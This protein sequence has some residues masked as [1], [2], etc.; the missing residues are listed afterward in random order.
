[1]AVGTRVVPALLALPNN[2]D[3]RMASVAVP[4]DDVATRVLDAA[5]FVSV[6]LFAFL[7]MAISGEALGGGGGWRL[8]RDG[9][10]VEVTRR[11]KRPS[12]KMER[13]RRKGRV[14]PQ[15]SED[16]PLGSAA[17]WPSLIPRGGTGMI[18]R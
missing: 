13:H 3:P 14:E 10:C 18:K 12:S 1:M 17:R 11:A 5:P 8:G 9:D 6:A 4:V 2:A 7:G 15:E 16:S